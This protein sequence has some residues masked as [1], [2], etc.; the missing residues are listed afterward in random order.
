MRS[1]FQDCDNFVT[2]P[3]IHVPKPLDPSE[4]DYLF[5]ERLDDEFSGLSKDV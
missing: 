3:S 5:I 4:Q 1:A 2:S